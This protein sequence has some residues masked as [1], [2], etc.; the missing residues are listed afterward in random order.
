MAH[1]ARTSNPINWGVSRCVADSG[2]RE[3]VAFVV[4]REK[5]KVDVVR[6]DR[7]EFT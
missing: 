5:K 6:M 2:S 3:I 7:R 1:A 4:E